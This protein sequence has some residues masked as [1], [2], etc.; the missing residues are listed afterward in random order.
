M[1]YTI[2]LNEDQLRTVCSAL[3]MFARVGIGQ[4]ETITGM[5]WP[6]VDHLGDIEKLN[7]GLF[8][9]K[10]EI[11]HLAPGASLGIHNKKASDDVR[12]AYDI[13]RASRHEI[14]KASEA[15]RDWLFSVDR[16]PTRPITDH[17]IVKITHHA[18]NDL[19]SAGAP[20]Q[21]GAEQTGSEESLPA[22][23]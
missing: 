19:P 12:V 20:D 3:D 8:A 7:A 13:L 15:E 11:L 22:T 10:Q 6:I 9:L 21:T 14:W 23:T 4:I 5:L 18:D 1:N 17:G 16:W 2:T